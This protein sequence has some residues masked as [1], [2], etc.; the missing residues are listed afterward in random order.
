MSWFSPSCLFHLEACKQWCQGSLVMNHSVLIRRCLSFLYIQSIRVQGALLLAN[1]QVWEWLY[2]AMG[3]SSQ[4]FTRNKR[5][6]ERCSSNSVSYIY[7]AID[8]VISCRTRKHMSNKYTYS[9]NN[10]WHYVTLYNKNLSETSNTRWLAKLRFHG[11]IE[12]AALVFALSASNN[13]QLWRTGGGWRW[14]HHPKQ[15]MI[16]WWSFGLT[17]CLSWGNMVIFVI[18]CDTL[19]TPLSNAASVGRSARQNWTT[20]QVHGSCSSAT[21]VHWHGETAAKF[22]QAA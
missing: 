10:M 5:K 20:A 3:D 18:P 16:S 2:L 11:V 9:T 4:R 13:D 15:E 6:I 17:N 22:L 1:I 8:C 14:F 7:T 21:F 12:H 19:K